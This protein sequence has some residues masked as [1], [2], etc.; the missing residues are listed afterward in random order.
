M[1]T[2]NVLGTAPLVKPGVT[3]ITE[4]VRPRTGG[5]ENTVSVRVNNAASPNAIFN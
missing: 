5:L 1:L 4:P 3:A 2:L